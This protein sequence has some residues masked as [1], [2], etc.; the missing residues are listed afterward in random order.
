LAESK[1]G[2]VVRR[3]VG[4][5]HIPQLFAEQV[6]AFCANYLNPYVNF[7]CP[8]FFPET[9]T[10]AKGRARERCRYENMKTPFERWKSMSQARQ[11]LTLGMTVERLDAQAA[12][13]NGTEVALVLNHA[14]STLFQS[15]SAAS[16]NQA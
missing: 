14:R 16:R 1:T 5:A 13:M 12:R 15:I 8:C 6:N 4:Y 3:Q 2:T 9:I 11:D 7:H 10:D